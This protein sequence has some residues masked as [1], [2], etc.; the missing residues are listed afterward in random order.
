MAKSKSKKEPASAASAAHYAS[1]EASPAA[2]P[3]PPLPTPSQRFSPL[4]L[5]SILP[6]QILLLHSFFPAK[7]C[8]NWLAFLSDTKHIPLEPSPAAKRGEAAR[9]NHRFSVTDSDFAEALW[10]QTGLKDAVLDSTS[11]HIFESSERAGA[12]PVGLNPNIRVRMDIGERCAPGRG[13]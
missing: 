12:R 8:A 13:D 11:E 6:S 3:W 1:T 9:T 5:D 7:A 4:E 10:S 2:I